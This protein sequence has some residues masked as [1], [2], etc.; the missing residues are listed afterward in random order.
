MWLQWP[1]D[2]LVIDIVD[3]S[4][5]NGVCFQSETRFGKAAA[6]A[7]YVRLSFA[8]YGTPELV[9]GAKRL[10]AVLR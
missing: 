9:E 4:R 8:H 1:N 10:G 6:M 7:R 5:R 3:E 2:K